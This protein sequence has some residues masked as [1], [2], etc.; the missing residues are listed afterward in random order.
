M[1]KSD[2]LKQRRSVLRRLATSAKYKRSFEFDPYGNKVTLQQQAINQ[3]NPILRE[4]QLLGLDVSLQ[5][6]QGSEKK[7]LETFDR[8]IRKELG[9]LKSKIALTPQDYIKAVQKNQNLLVDISTPQLGMRYFQDNA[10]LDKIPGLTNT[11]DKAWAISEIAK[12]PVINELKQKQQIFKNQSNFDIATTLY[13]NASFADYYIKGQGGKIRQIV[14]ASKSVDVTDFALIRMAQSQAGGLKSYIQKTF[15]RENKFVVDLVN[16]LSQM[17]VS[18]N[19]KKCESFLTALAEADI[20]TRQIAAFIEDM[21]DTF[22]VQDNV[23]NSKDED[24][25]N[26]YSSNELKDKYNKGY[27]KALEN[28]IKAMNQYLRRA[29]K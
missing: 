29:I 14:K 25:D 12:L 4:I 28:Y 11:S 13:T 26:N 21:K 8:Q 10:K 17:E 16:Q 19:V 27:K 2:I 7:R 24:E 23:T 15:G 6:A 22:D 9:L 3:T 1:N 20:S 5:Y 18:N